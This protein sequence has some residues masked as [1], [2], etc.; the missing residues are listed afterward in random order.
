VAIGNPLGLEQTITRGIISGINRVLPS[1]PMSMMV[2][3][4]QTDTA[5]NP[6]NSGGPLLNL[7]GEV[8]GINTAT[9]MGV[10]N[11]GFAIPIN[12]AKQVVPQL[13]QRGRFIRPWLGTAGKLISKDLGA[14]F[15]IP[16]VDGFLVE[17]LEPGSPAENAG[18]QGGVLPTRKMDLAALAEKICEVHEIHGGELRSG[19]RRGEIV[20]ARRVLSWMAVKELGYSGAAVARYLGVTNSCVTRAVSAEKVPQKE[21]YI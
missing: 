18:V 11:I 16:M 10:E 17:T 15:N 1:S 20:E 21:R 4:I 14:V 5:I 6:G 19:S 13:V 9:L 8:I 3:L 12:I 2:P 7:C